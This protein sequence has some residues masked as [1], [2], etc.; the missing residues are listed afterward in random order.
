MVRRCSSSI[1]GAKAQ[2][3]PMVLPET[4]FVQED[5]EKA[6]SGIP[7]FRW[8]STQ[9]EQQCNIGLCPPAPIGFSHGVQATD[10]ISLVSIHLRHGNITAHMLKS[11]HVRCAMGDKVGSNTRFVH[12]RIRSPWITTSQ[13]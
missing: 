8:S 5:L 12:F 13:Q 2:N 4:T 10:L 11:T 1:A 6:I 3:A 9:L 7:G